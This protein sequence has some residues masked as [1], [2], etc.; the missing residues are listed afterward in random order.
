MGTIA[1][2]L[3]ALT[4]KS[5]GGGVDYKVYEGTINQVF[6]Q[7][8]FNVIDDTLRGSSTLKNN[9]FII[10]IPF[11]NG[12][13]C[14]PLAAWQWD[15]DGILLEFSHSLG[16]ANIVSTQLAGYILHTMLEVHITYLDGVVHN[17]NPW[18]LSIAYKLDDTDYVDVNTVIDM[19]DTFNLILVEATVKLYTI[20]HPIE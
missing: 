1:E 13:F 8:P 3:H 17:V 7:L 6:M 4:A 2:E 12:S 14:I 20:N 16:D 10:E 18:I 5:K 11:N 19:S 15:D 9:S